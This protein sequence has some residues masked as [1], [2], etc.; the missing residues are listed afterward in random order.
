MGQDAAQYLAQITWNGTAPNPWP[1]TGMDTDFGW[2]TVQQNGCENCHAPHNAIGQKRLLNCYTELG[3]CNPAT[4]EGVCFP[5]HN[6][7]MLPPVKNIFAQ[8][9]N[10]SRHAVDLYDR[11]YTI[12]KSLRKLITGH[13]ECVDC[14]NPHM[15]NNIKQPLRRPY[16]AAWTA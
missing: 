13:V 7:N 15:T 10:T 14:H 1:R 4:E 16:R 2:T 9:L 12:R 11:H 8:F 6:G 3:P 5:C